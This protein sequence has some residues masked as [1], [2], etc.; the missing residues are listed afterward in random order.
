MTAP[1]PDIRRANKAQAAQFFDVSLPTVEKWMREGCPYVQRGG[2]GVGWVLDLLAM[3]EWRFSARANGSEA[4]PESMPAAERKQWYEGEQKRRDIQIR[5]RELIPAIEVEE[6]MATAF[7]AISQ[8]LRSMPDNLERRLGIAPEITEAIEAQ[9]DDEMQA[10][11]DRLE[12]LA[13]VGDGR[14]DAA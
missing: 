5:D 1:V 8:G 7:A 2:K 10:L 14:E 9:M 6:A 4:D 13:P 11:A 3:A 12:S